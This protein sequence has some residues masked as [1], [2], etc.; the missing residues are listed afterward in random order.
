MKIPAAFYDD[1][2]DDDDDRYKRRYDESLH[3][4]EY[5]HYPDEEDFH[6]RKKAKGKGRRD[7]IDIFDKKY[8]SKTAHALGKWWGDTSDAWPKKW[9]DLNPYQMPWTDPYSKWTDYNNSHRPDV[10][11]SVRTLLDKMNN[12]GA[13]ERVAAPSEHQIKQGELLLDLVYARWVY[14]STY[15]TLF[16]L[17]LI[18]EHISKGKGK[19]K[20]TSRA[21]LVLHRRVNLV[22][23][24]LEA[25]KYA[26]KWELGN[27]LKQ[28]QMQ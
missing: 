16:R 21:K 6:P 27:G 8:P 22:P 9:K 28:H 1:D 15:S 18:H 2:D 3:P 26:M 24:A 4:K 13:F 25:M 5:N 10:R 19:K 12:E 20:E 14:S 23:N 11:E 17:S 7:Y